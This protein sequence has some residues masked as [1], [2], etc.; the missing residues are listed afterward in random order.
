[1]Q[2]TGAQLH[3]FTWLD[4]SLIGEV[5]KVWNWLPDEFGPNPDAKL[6]HYTLGTP[7]F[8]EYSTTPMGEE[9]HRERMF[10]DYCLQHGSTQPGE[11]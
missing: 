10:A 9:W 3:R 4:D 2:A 5:P 6:L 7:C 1:M 8:H 11:G